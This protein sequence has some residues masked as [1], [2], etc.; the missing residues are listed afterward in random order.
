MPAPARK[1]RVGP[2]QELHCRQ[3]PVR[4]PGQGRPR[5]G[6][7]PTDAHH[8]HRGVRA[9]E[10]DRPALLGRAL[11]PDAVQQDRHRSLRRDP[12][13]L[14]VAEKIIGQQKGEFDS[15]QFVRDEL[16]RVPL[17]AHI[18][19]RAGFVYCFLRGGGGTWGIAPGR[20]SCADGHRAISLPQC[21]AGLRRIIPRPNVIFGTFS[22]SFFLHSWATWL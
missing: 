13:M 11:S 2:G 14:E 12:H 18:C 21:R 7:A 3:G 8:R 4:A 10:V 1:S 15:T 6:E 20:P 16:N 9:G 19:E 22:T 17:H 5:R